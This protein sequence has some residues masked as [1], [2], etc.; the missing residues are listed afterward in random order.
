MFLGFLQLPDTAR[1]AS[2]ARIPNGKVRDSEDRANIWRGWQNQSKQTLE[3]LG[4]GG[5]LA[6]TLR[7]AAFLVTSHVES[8]GPCPGLG[9][10]LASLGRRRN[11]VFLDRQIC[12]W[13][14]KFILKQCMLES[15]LLA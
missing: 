2:Q 13:G 9:S 15:W 4:L 3:A 1:R 11:L 8:M 10:G 6:Q 7:A 5:P 14:Q 12:F